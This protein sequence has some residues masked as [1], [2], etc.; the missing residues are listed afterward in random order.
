VGSLL[1][2]DGCRTA[3]VNVVQLHM[4]DIMD[5]KRKPCGSLAEAA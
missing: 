1:V 3:A 5:G 4:Q 2:I